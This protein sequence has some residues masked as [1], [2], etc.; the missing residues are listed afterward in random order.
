M[1]VKNNQ[2][3][4]KKQNDQTKELENQIETMLDDIMK[5][6]EDENQINFELEY[7][8]NSSENEENNLMPEESEKIFL[9]YLI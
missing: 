6:E 7:D 4:D 3:K 8:E 9:I 5:E 2:L 1:N